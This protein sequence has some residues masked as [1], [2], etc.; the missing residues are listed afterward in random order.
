MKTAKRICFVNDYFL[1]DRTATITGPMV[2]MYLLGTGLAKRG[3]RVEFIATTHSGR[4]GTMEVHDGVRVHYVRAAK[5]LE[6]GSA[7]AVKRKLRSIEADAFYQRGRSMLTGITAEAAHARGAK[8]VWASAGE[9]GCRR[10]R[11]MGQQ[12]PRKSLWKRPIYWPVYMWADRLYE[13]GIASAD[14]VIVQTKYQQEE[15]KKEFQRDSVIM[16]SGHPVPP[17]SVLKKKEPPVV[18]WIG[19]VKPAKQPH[20][21]L[22]LVEKCE[23][24]DARF[25]LVGRIEDAHWRERLTQTAG[26]NPKFSFRDEVPFDEVS[27]VFAEAS[28]LVNTTIPDYEGLPNAFI[29]AWLHGVPVVSLHANPD[30]V[31]E[32]KGIGQNV[33][34][35][36]K[37]VEATRSLVIHNESRNQMGRRARAFAVEEYGLDGILTDFE[38]IIA[39]P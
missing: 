39:V 6:V 27:R 29:Q 25:Q 18:L 33:E 28:V 2:Q 19:S 32:K 20:L 31:L 13:R 12:L 11:Y 22:E 30:G 9:S 7:L 14:I 24:L 21:F 26:R 15:L 8:F 16:K 1:K 5:R 36:D 34:S 38:R 37:L 23:D 3:W 10:R 4:A 35:F 17:E